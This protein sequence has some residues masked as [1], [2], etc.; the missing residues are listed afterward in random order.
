MGRASSPFSEGGAY[1]RQTQPR[2]RLAQSG[3]VRS[4]GMETGSST[5][6]G[7]VSL[8]RDSSSRSICDPAL[9]TAA[10]VLLPLPNTGCRRTRRSLISVTSRASLRLPPNPGHSQGDPE[11]D[12]GVGRSTSCGATLAS[13]GV[14]RR[15][16]VPVRRGTV[17]NSTGSDFSH[18]RRR[19]P[20][21]TRMALFDRLA[22]ERIRLTKSHLSSEV[23]SIIQTARRPSTVHIYNASWKAFARCCALHHVDPTS[24]TVPDVLQF[25]HSGF[26]D[27]LAPSTLKVAA[28]ATVLIGDNQQSLSHDSRIKSFLQG[29]SHLRPPAIHRYPT[30]DLT[31]VL[32][33]LTSAPFEPI[34][35]ASLRFLTLKMA[36]LLA[37][38]SARRVSEIAAFSIRSDLCVFYQDR[39]VLRLDPA[40]IPKINTPFHRVQDIVLPNFCPDPRHPSEKRW[41]TLDVRKALKRYISRTAS[42][43]K[44]EALLVSFLPSSLG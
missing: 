5:V 9:H 37:I 43:R 2:G 35:T 21:R 23:I 38:T 18:S 36:F 19:T 31:L 15:Y 16:S 44:T 12:Q 14:V 22:L 40:F 20:S 17:A 8:V 7:S 11:S 13:S 3:P 33:D 6:S 42:F 10:K 25:L 30:W 28:L 29:A 24:A 34:C 4:L 27:G 41:H 26:A 1:L 32:Q 39:V